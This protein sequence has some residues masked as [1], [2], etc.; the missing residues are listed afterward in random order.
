M[1]WIKPNV[2]WM[3]YRSGWGTKEGQES[4]LALRLRRGFFDRVLSAS[5]P[6]SWD[7]DLFDSEE[8]WS[9]AVDAS[10]VRIQWDPDHDPNGGKVERRAIQLGLRGEMLEAFGKRELLE[11]ID[12]TEFVEDQRQ[13]L[14]TSGVP[15]LSTPTEFIYRPP[16][17]AIA[18][19]LR[20]SNEG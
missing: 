19:K 13:A 9:R 16:D 7:P 8:A 10:S 4:V 5:V 6:S 15:S 3:M 11:V 14:N 20:L 1:S 18:R 2:L 17:S 12:M